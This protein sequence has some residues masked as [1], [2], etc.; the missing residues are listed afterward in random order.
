MQHPRP[1]RLLCCVVLL[2]LTPAYT[3]H[4]PVSVR[5]RS[6]LLSGV[7]TRRHG[8]CRAQSVARESLLEEEDGRPR[9]S[10]F[11][12]ALPE[13]SSTDHG[14][15]L[16]AESIPPVLD[17]LR[18]GSFVLLA[19]DAEEN[20]LRNLAEGARQAEARRERKGRGYTEESDFKSEFGLVI[21]QE[22]SG[23]A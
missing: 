4:A 17:A 10:S 11:Q 2:H 7:T 21:E 9:R 5:E 23:W 3:Y 18:A 8:L 16:G 12:P 6:A 19:E 1:S 20:R 13:S 15:V 14:Y 22:K